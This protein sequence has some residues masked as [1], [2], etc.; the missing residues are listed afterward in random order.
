MITIS[1]ATGLAFCALLIGGIF[2]LTNHNASKTKS[3]AETIPLLNEKEIKFNDD[4]RL[5]REEQTKQQ[6]LEENFRIKIKEIEKQK[7]KLEEDVAQ[8][9]KLEDELKIRV[10]EIEK[11][12]IKL[13][14]DVKVFQEKVIQ[15]KHMKDELESRSNEMEKRETKLQEDV[16][17][18]QGR[19]V[20]QKQMQDEFKTC[21]LYTSPS[22]RDLA[23]SR[24]PSAA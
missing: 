20:Q 12:D 22:P 16:Q 18:F 10:D 2:L 15:Q 17:V 1:T 13:Q 21:L 14:E 24:M 11:R 8:Q 9:Q 4:T 5:L 3:T 23:R 6:K 7:T 19:I